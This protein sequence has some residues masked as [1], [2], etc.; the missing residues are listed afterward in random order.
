MDGWGTMTELEFV[1]LPRGR[2]W[3]V[4]ANGKDCGVAGNK[5]QA[6]AAAFNWAQSSYDRGYLVSIGRVTETGE[7]Q[8]V[9]WLGLAEMRSARGAPS[10][11]RTAD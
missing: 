3:H 8:T 11:R 5:E 7:L 9:W 6:L 4:E 10:V 2:V 1:I